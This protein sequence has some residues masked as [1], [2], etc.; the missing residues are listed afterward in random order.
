[1]ASFA[2]VGVPLYFEKLGT[3]VYLKHAGTLG[4]NCQSA[5]SID[6]SS[7]VPASVYANVA[8]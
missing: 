5:G 1:M 7:A 8:N 4:Q 3:G 2:N 6:V